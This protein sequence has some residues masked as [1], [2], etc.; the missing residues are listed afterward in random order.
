ML[1]KYWKIIIVSLIIIVAGGVYYNYFYKSETTAQTTINPGNIMEIEKGSLAKTIAAEGF[2]QPI[3]EEDLSVPSKSSGS[4]KVKKIYVKEGDR[5][6]EG[7]LLM[8]LDKTEAR[9]NYIQK[10]N[11]YNR[12]KINGSKSEIEEAKLGLELAT[13]E[14]ENLDLK[15]PFSGII[16]DID[17]EEGSYYNDGDVATIK[18]ISRL[19]VEIS[20]EESEIPIVKLGQQVKA[21]LSSLPR[22]E[23]SGEVVELGN[24]ANN[25]SS[26]VTLPV[27][28]LLEEVDYDIK[29]GVS[30]DLDI[31]VGEVKDKVII[32]ITAII[33]RNGKDFVIKV[34][35]GKTQEVPVE[36]GL[37]DGL[38]IAIESGLEAGDKILVNTFQQALEFGSD[39][40]DNRMM[41]PGPGMTGGRR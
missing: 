37:S 24:E 5:V 9:L 8:E 33:T 32:P 2:I 35:N 21:T 30:A 22:I 36:T 4:T 39:S 25:D 41:G 14:L 34:V 38:K 17:I 19:E 12:A 26:I 10:Q 31:I 13:F 28:V 27:T 23:L 3:D 1:R 15:A 40:N 11:S 18:D 29:L 6:E 20:I 16:T 7:Q